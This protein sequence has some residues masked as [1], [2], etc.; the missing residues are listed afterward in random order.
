[1]RSKAAIV[2]LLALTATGTACA[3]DVGRYRNSLLGLE[4]GRGRAASTPAD[5]AS[6]TAPETPAEATTGVAPDAAATETTVPAATVVT[7]AALGAASVTPVSG[8]AARVAQQPAGTTG[9]TAAGGTRAAGSSGSGGGGTATSGAGG[10]GPSVAAASGSSSS[11][12]APSGGASGSDATVPAP[13]PRGGT[14]TGVTKDAITIGFFYPKTGHYTGLARN[15]PAVAQAAFDSAGL[16][17]GRRLVLKL[18]DDGS[19]NA[20][21]IQLEEKRAKDEVFALMSV[22]SESNVVLAPLADQHKV[23][24]VVGNIDEK[25]ALP[26]TYSFPVFAFW[27]RQATILPSFIKNA[28]N[29]GGKKIGIVYEGTSTATDAKNAFK[30]KAKELGLNVAFEQPIAVA[31]ST[32]A[33]EVSNLQSRGIELVYMMNGPLGAI[34]MLRDARALAYKPIWTGVGVSW[35]FNVV[36]QASGGAADG[37]RTISTTTTL[38]SPA[39]QRYA[40]MMRKHS[41]NSGA[42]T[43][44]LMLM[45][46]SL[47]H[48]T[49]EALRRAGPDLSRESFVQTMETKMNGYDSGY[50][51]PPT[52]GPRIRYGPTSVGVHTCCTDGRWTTAQQ[53]WRPTF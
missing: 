34:C 41:P 3:G 1:M 50:L 47:V 44:D 38:E 27:A 15:A 13:V 5:G 29:A 22:V 52:F 48:T 39:G 4:A 32:C 6:A 17:N 24:V 20:S 33:N 26:L 14:T 40:E 42:D 28:L 18:Y 49:I 30:A 31:Q 16:I 21:T 7:G 8:P 11:G 10:G 19:A 12:P 46:Y 23:P 43:D 36:A 45:F 35:S 51:P 25:V 37:I 9:A 53:G 2:L